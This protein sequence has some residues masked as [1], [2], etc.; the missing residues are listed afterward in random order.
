MST[1]HKVKVEAKPT[2]LW[3]D[4]GW[5]ESED[6]CLCNLELLDI[7]SYGKR[8]ST[9]T[10]FHLKIFKF[11]LGLGIYPATPGSTTTL[12]V[13][14]PVCTRC[15]ENVAYESGVCWDCLDG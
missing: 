10:I 5:Y 3:G 1:G 7:R 9:I 15:G 13:D 2:A 6:F 4:F 14:E 11:V 12:A 8:V